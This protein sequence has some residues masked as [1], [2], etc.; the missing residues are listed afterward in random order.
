MERACTPSVFFY[1]TLPTFSGTCFIKFLYLNTVSLPRSHIAVDIF[2]SPTLSNVVGTLEEHRAS[3]TKVSPQTIPQGILE[4]QQPKEKQLRGFFSASL[5]C[6]GSGEGLTRGCRV[7]SE[8]GCCRDSPGT[9]GGMQKYPELPRDVLSGPGPCAAAL[10]GCSHWAG[11]NGWRVWGGSKA[12]SFPIP[13][14]TGRALSSAFCCSQVRVTAAW[15]FSS[16]LSSL[17]G[18]LREGVWA[19]LTWNSC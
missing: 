11:W 6:W 12:E 8:T 17:E 2:I 13:A 3:I 18:C 16:I 5:F 10:P 7:C 9:W 19:V 15:S 14:R 1:F 4:F